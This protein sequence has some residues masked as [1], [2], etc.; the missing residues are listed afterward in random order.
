MATLLFPDNVEPS[1]RRPSASVPGKAR[2]RRFL[3]LDGVRGLAVIAVLVTHASYAIHNRIVFRVF[4]MGW[5]GVDLFFVLSGF[6]ITGILLD[7]RSAVN[8]AGSFYARR[9]LRIFPIYYL[10]LGLALLAQARWAWVAA[11]ADMPTLGSRL[12]YLFYYTNFISLW[13]HGIAHQ[14]L[15]SH[16]WSLAVEEQFYFV[17]PLI[18]WHISTK[19]VYRLC[20][21]AVCFTLILRVVSGW[22]FGYG[23]WL[24]L[25]TPTRADGLFVGAGLAAL[26][27]SKPPSFQADSGW[28]CA[29]RPGGIS[30]R[31][32]PWTPA[33]V[34]RRPADEHLWIYLRSSSL[35]RPDCLL[36][37]PPRFNPFPRL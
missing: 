36:H 4:Q 37:P 11:D 15:L 17:W 1:L 14:T 27:A 31:S 13:H 7:T 26:L 28:T 9:V 3:A 18:V 23:V 8:R 10:T 34:F 16:F 33:N 25:L 32:S 21:A 29:A 19:T 30:H 35:R 22:Y 12:P 6:L 2:R 24:F 5:T 20:G